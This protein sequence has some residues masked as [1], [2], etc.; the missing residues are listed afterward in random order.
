MLQA[1]AVS[2]IWR[3]GPVYTQS[4]ASIVCMT[5]TL[6]N[7]W[8]GHFT[9]T[10]VKEVRLREVQALWHVKDVREVA[11]RCAIYR[12][13]LR[14]L[15]QRE[16]GD[17]GLEFSDQEWFAGRLTSEV[18]TLVEARARSELHASVHLASMPDVFRQLCS[19]AG[20]DRSFTEQ[21][22]ET[23]RIQDDWFN[24]E[25]CIKAD[26]E[27]AHPHNAFTVIAILNRPLDG[28]GD[29]AVGA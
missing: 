25:K 29:L 16:F 7:E 19:R 10:S 23:K 5:N 21:M 22:D 15:V 1:N 13:L 24:T 20:Q 3:V 2:P 26:E 9:G 11:L 6:I 4:V 14:P 12:N 27:R 28:H 18:S 17:N 8:K